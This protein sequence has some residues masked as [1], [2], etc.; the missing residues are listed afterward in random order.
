MANYSVYDV[1]EWFLQKE[2]MTHKKLQKMCYYAQ[3][4]SYALLNEP[5]MDTKFEAW[6]HG[7]VS[8]ELYN[9]YKGN[10]WKDLEPENRELSFDP[11]T[12]DLLESV[13]VTY[14]DLSGNSLEALTHSEFPWQNARRGC[15]PNEGCNRVIDPF[16]MAKYYK[17]IYTGGEE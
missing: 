5:L 13:Y 17:S 16:D 15:K 7:P 9:K 14:K 8:P 11:K 6:I 4:W 1:A 2:K 3:A 12:V 10:S